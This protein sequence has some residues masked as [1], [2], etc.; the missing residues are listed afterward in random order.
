V[1]L[2]CSHISLEEIAS[3]ICFT[4]CALGV[5]LSAKLAVQLHPK[6]FGGVGDFQDMIIE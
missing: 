5:L 4:G 6:A 3:A 1:S 2:A